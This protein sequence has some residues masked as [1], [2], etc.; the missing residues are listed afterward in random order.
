MRRLLAC[1]CLCL[2]AP[3]AALAEDVDV[4]LVLMADASGSIDM[5]E[6]RLQR[7]GYA[8]A[9][10][11]PGVL[12]AIADGAHGRIAVAYV[13]WADAFSQDVVVDWMVIDGAEA[14]G[15]FGAR[16][17]EAPRRA[18]GRNAIGAAL[19]KATQMIEEGPHEGFR[20]VID[21]SADSANSWSGP[22]IE[23]GRQAAL[24][25]GI[26]ING[27]AVLCLD[28]ATSRPVSYDLEAA[29]RERIVGGP[30]HFVVTADGEQA[31]AEAVR[32][33]LILEIAGLEPGSRPALA[34][35]VPR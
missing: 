13:E 27:L 17:A 14:A 34:T 31:F 4:E 32:R 23:E 21:F 11:D 29:F 2:A 19:L 20:K 33:K 10:A 28:C 35:L 8:R 15:G 25:A 30:G 16:L 26:T 24:A 1:L 6:L 22:P 18:F 5:A 7:D 12:R 9:M 3:L